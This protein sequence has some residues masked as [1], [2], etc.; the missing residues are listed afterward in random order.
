MYRGFLPV[1]VELFGFDSVTYSIGESCSQLEVVVERD[2]SG[3]YTTLG[4]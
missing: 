3:N 4:K 1:E 2:G